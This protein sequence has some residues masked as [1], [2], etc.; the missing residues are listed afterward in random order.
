MSHY[1]IVK[2]QRYWIKP[3]WHLKLLDM[4]GFSINKIKYESKKD[5]YPYTTAYENIIVETETK[6]LLIDY[7][8]GNIHQD[9]L[10]VGEKLVINDETF[11]IKNV[12]KH[13]DGKVTYQVDDLYENIENY[14]ELLVECEKKYE[15]HSVQL[16]TE[17][18]NRQT[19]LNN[20]I[21]ENT[22]ETTKKTS[23]WQRLF[24]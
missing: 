18:F 2:R 19:E 13:V 14:D 4:Y 6:G 17:K 11:T 24:N 3:E 23:F 5:D 10:N 20:T 9:I 1:A 12:E 7:W 21:I 16:K 15:E 22:T 8:E